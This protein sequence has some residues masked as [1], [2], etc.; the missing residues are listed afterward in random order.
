MRSRGSPTGSSSSSYSATDKPAVEL[1]NSANLDGFGEKFVPNLC[2]N[3]HGGEKYFP[4]NVAAPTATEVALRPLVGPAIGASFREFDTDSFR[5]PNGAVS[6][7]PALRQQFHQL[8]QLVKATNPQQAIVDLVTEWTKGLPIDPPNTS[9]VPTAWTV[10]NDTKQLYQQVVAKNCR[11]CHVALGP[12][13]SWATYEQFKDRHLAI[14]PDVCGPNKVMP[15]ALMAYRNF[16]LSAGPRR[17]E[18]L[19]KFS[20]PGWMPFAGGCK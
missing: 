4:K 1:I 16:W 10:S 9:F 15:H 19:S 11:T 12:T 2:I 6:L 7:P 3:C 13:L 5:Y 20:A 14:L 18:V 17:P 8:N